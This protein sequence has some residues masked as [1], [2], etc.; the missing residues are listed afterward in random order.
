MRCRASESISFSSATS[1]H[2]L[3]AIALLDASAPCTWKAC[4]PAMVMSLRTCGDASML[5]IVLLFMFMLCRA[6]GGD[7]EARAEW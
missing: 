2:A 6:C 7:T 5:V 1:L 4:M 3:L